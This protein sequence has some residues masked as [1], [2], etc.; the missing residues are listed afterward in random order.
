MS[1][2]CPL[3]VISRHTSSK[4]KLVD[5][6]LVLHPKSLPHPRLSLRIA[7]AHVGRG[8]A[9]DHGGIALHASAEFTH[10]QMAPFTSQVHQHGASMDQGALL[11]GGENHTR[12]KYLHLS[13]GGQECSECDPPRADRHVARVGRPPIPLLKKVFVAEKPLIHRLVK[14]VLMSVSE[15]IPHEFPVDLP[16][17]ADLS[18]KR[19]QH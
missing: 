7:L 5:P 17:S 11:P 13:D 14:V 19:G 12:G 15:T 8:E 6:W 16:C 3:P 1:E 9:A 2:R 18:M 4:P 10:G